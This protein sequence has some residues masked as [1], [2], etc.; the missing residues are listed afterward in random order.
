MKDKEKFNTILI[1]LA[2]VIVFVVGVTFIIF[3]NYINEAG[4]INEEI[5]EIAP[6]SIIVKR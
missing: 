6:Q 1:T 3:T 4:N 5:G 2:V